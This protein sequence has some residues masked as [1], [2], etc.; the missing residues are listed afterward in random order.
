MANLGLWEFAM[1]TCKLPLVFCLTACITTV[2]TR[3]LSADIT[4]AS[5]VSDAQSYAQAVG[6]VTGP[7]QIQTD[8]LPANLSTQA[9]AP[10]AKG[11]FGAW[12]WSTSNSSI[13]VDNSLG[14][15]RVVGDG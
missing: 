10:A 5:R 7:P 13:S 9:F 2:V 11:G 1:K 4:L 8:F 3:R 14:T 12:A 15:M 6:D